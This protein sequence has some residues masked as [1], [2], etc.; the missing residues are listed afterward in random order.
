M[1]VP[2]VPEPPLGLEEVVELF[3]KEKQLP[4]QEPLEGQ[5]ELVQGECGGFTPMIPLESKCECETIK[6]NTHAYQGQFKRS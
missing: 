4:L 6:Y 2:L 5:E 3:A 1:V